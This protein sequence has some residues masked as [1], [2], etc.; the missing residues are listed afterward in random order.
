MKD[1]KINSALQLG[2]LRAEIVINSLN[3]FSRDGSLVTGGDCSKQIRNPSAAETAGS[4]KTELRSAVLN[5]VEY[6]IV[7]PPLFT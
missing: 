3:L 1:V 2:I 5:C 4:M 6:F 7:V